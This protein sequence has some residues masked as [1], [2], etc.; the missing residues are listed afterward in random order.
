MTSRYTKRPNRLS[1]IISWFVAL[2]DFLVWVKEWTLFS[3]RSAKAA[4]GKV[5]YNDWNWSNREVCL[6]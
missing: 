2:N 4:R 6:N 1:V 3:A 5:F